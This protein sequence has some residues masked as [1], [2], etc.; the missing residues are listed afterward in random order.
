MFPYRQ[1]L[2]VSILERGSSGL[3]QRQAKVERALTRKTSIGTPQASLSAGVILTIKSI[4]DSKRRSE[5][6][7]AC[8]SLI[9][10]NGLRGLERALSIRKETVNNSEKQSKR[11]TV[12]KDTD[13]SK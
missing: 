9:T 5:I 13:A 11:R 8:L 4:L 6:R 1:G 2:L 10:G 12:P 7:Y 3:D